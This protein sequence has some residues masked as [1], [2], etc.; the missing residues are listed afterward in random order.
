MKQALL[1][2][3]IS[4]V[5]GSALA[6]EKFVMKPPLQRQLE[7]LV[8]PEFRLADTDLMDALLYLQKKAQKAPQGAIRVPFVVH[9]P[10]DFKPR[11]ELFL[12]LKA[13]PFWA[14]LGHLCGQAG[15]G[16][17]I[18]RE[19]I[20]IRP[21]QSV[22]GV[23]ATVRTEIPAPAEPAPARGLSGP[24]GKPARPFVTGQNVHHA[25]SGEI[26]PKKSG[27]GAHRNLNGWPIDVDPRG[28]MSMNCIDQVKCKAKCCEN[29]ACGC[30]ACSCHNLK[31]EK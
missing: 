30:I 4:L 20:A 10:A 29:G 15:V 25:M 28:A 8:L 16:F 2:F 9:L 31:V 18:E 21:L 12:D 27:S 23:K 1:G 13:V 6:D 17:S 3:V 7:S 26:Q 11:H 5:A 24:L 14:A 22:A 19:A